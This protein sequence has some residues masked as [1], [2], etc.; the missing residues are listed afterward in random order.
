MATAT[1]YRYLCRYY[2]GTATVAHLDMC[3]TK[4]FISQAEYD[5]ALTGEPPEGYI[6]PSAAQEAPPA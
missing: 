5:R 2:E 6:A 4:G 1:G 3:L